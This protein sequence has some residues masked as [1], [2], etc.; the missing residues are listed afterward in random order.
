MTY[1]FNGSGL[2]EFYVKSILSGGHKALPYIHSKK[3]VGAGFIPARYGRLK[4]PLPTILINVK[5]GGEIFKVDEIIKNIPK[6]KGYNC[7]AC[8]TT[9]PIGLNLTFYRRGEYVCS[10][11]KL[12][13]NYE[14]WEN[15]A[16]GGIISTLLDEV[17]GWALIYFKKFFL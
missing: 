11:I 15:M 4:S 13:R 10:D 17:M 8:G 3:F 6:L 1:L 5:E 7:F 2:K 12:G 9:N 16:H 14:G